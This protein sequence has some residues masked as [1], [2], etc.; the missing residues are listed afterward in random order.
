MATN[1]QKKNVS[2]P[3]AIINMNAKRAPK[4]A[5]K[6]ETAEGAI[7]AATI[8]EC[9]CDKVALDDAEAAFKASSAAVKAF[10]SEYMQGKPGT[11]NFPGTEV[12]AQISI[13]R[14]SHALRDAETA[15]RVAGTRF[16]RYVDEKVVGV[17]YAVSARDRARVVDILRAAGEDP[18]ALLRETIQAEYTVREQYEADLNDGT[19]DAVLGDATE[20]FKGCIDSRTGSVSIK[21]VG[22]EE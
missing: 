3:P 9:Y 14:G 13:K 10:A 19:L 12:A 5:S 4:K 21:F 15:R 17:V 1:A 11:V 22:N 18:D 6:V 20:E 7:E 2:T 8:D 16:S